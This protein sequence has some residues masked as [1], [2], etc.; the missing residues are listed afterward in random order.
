MNLRQ[1]L[2]AL[3]ERMPSYIA[4]CHAQIKAIQ[5][6]N[7]SDFVKSVGEIVWKFSKPINE[8]LDRKNKKSL[9]CRMTKARSICAKKMHF[10]AYSEFHSNLYYLI[11]TTLDTI[12]TISQKI[13]TPLISLTCANINNYKTIYQQI[14]LIL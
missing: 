1:E 7:Y 10:E 14:I 8:I 11:K 5:T 4:K 12:I 3:I 2:Q 13:S 6:G 9:Y